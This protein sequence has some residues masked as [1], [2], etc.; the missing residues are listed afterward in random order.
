MRDATATGTVP[1]G[2]LSPEQLR[3]RIEA[4]EIMMVQLALPDL[5][6]RLKGKLYDARHFL[7]EIVDRGAEVCAYLLATDVDMRPVDG[8]A[9]ASWANGYP[10][11]RLVPDLTTARMLP[12]QHG[13]A[14]V[15]ADAVHADGRPVAVA[16]REVLRGQLALLAGHGLTLKAGLETEFA[17][18]KGAA[19]AAT[20]TGFRE[21][22]P[23]SG[24]NLDYALDHVP[25]LS[26]YLQD[27]PS[28]LA[29]VGLAVEALKTESG[30]GQVEVTFRY[31]EALTAA[32]NHTV[33]KQAAKAIAGRA[34]MTATFMAAPESGVG[35]G[36]HLH[37]SLWRGGQSVLA[38]A[39]GGLSALGRQ[40]IAG[41]LDGLPE[42][43]P[44][45]A[46]IVNSYKRFAD[47]S[48]A[49]TRFVWGRDNRTCAVRVVGHGPRLHLEV[50]LPG[51]DA[52]PY[53]ALAAAVAAARHGIEHDLNPPP[54]VVGNAY[55]ETDAPL[56]PGTLDTALDT[57]ARSRLSRNAFGAETVA[58]YTRAGEI[59]RDAL[60][61]TVTD[62]ERR[63]GLTRA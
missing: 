14:L 8:Y 60:R 16:P 48:F 4:G 5:Q 19:E 54:P 18:Y 50:R 53:L 58:H 30:G 32:D 29:G 1:G 55:Q 22:E 26:V 46:P 2:L 63:C 61:Y 51:A 35:S 13:T 33:F 52:N 62:A 57:F 3:A 44:L 41:L 12:W 47:A 24:D 11:L 42:L 6:G 10:D 20:A 34:Q 25:P 59:E 43:M 39:D 17:L 56:V 9:L 28:A 40:V 36:L 37:L 31:G 27:L 21:L 7:D 15:L 38:G 23:V 49:P 45:L